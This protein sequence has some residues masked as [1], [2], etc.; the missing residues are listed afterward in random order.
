MEALLAKLMLLLHGKG[1]L[2]VALALS[3]GGL[4]VT[5][6]VDGVPVDLKISSI[7]GRSCVEA[8][9]ARTGARLEIEERYVD[10]RELL[11]RLRDDARA[12]AD[13]RNA[14]IDER[15]LAAELERGLDEL[16]AARDEALRRLQ[17]IADLTPCEDGDRN[18]GAVTD[19][20]RLRQE[21]T[22]IVHDARAR[23]QAALDRAQAAFDRLVAS[24][25]PKAPK[26]PKGDTSDSDD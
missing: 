2:A 21:Y 7:E 18:T 25:T 16:K 20:A 8:L 26:P 5:G 4:V 22:A 17:S 6:T 12:R 15:A 1:A 13:E 14:R 23:S 10:G 11:R 19:L 24:A 3:T 9:L